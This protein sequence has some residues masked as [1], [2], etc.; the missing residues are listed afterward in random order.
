MWLNLYEIINSRYRKDECASLKHRS[1]IGTLIY[2]ELLSEVKVLDGNLFN[3]RLKV[4]VLNTFKLYV[5]FPFASPQLDCV[6]NFKRRFPRRTNKV[7]GTGAQFHTKTPLLIEI[8]NHCRGP[9]GI[10]F[11][12]SILRAALSDFTPGALIPSAR[13]GFISDAAAFHFLRS[14]PV[15]ITKV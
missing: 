2:N 7:W 13:R 6:T 10:R 4:W 3:I 9:V 1:Y 15:I 8:F 5:D 11:W 14:F 12:Y